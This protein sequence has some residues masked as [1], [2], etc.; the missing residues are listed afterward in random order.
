MAL[1]QNALHRLRPKMR[2]LR[3][4]SEGSEAGRLRSIARTKLF[5]A[6]WRYEIF[7]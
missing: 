6:G 4:D 3:N 1:I 5:D 2:E 7:A